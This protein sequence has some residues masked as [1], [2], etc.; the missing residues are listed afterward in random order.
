MR[1]AARQ[2]RAMQWL[3]EAAWAQFEKDGTDV[4]RLVTAHRGWLD[5]YGDYVLWSGVWE[6]GADEAIR[7]QLRERFRFEPRGWLVRDLAK[8]A[9][10]QAPPRLICGERPQ[11]FVAREAGIRYAVDPAAG[12]ASG[13][14]LDQRLNRAWARR[15]EA[16]RMLN[17]FAYTCSFSVCAALSG[18]TTSSVDSSRRALA[19]GKENFALN[20]LDVSAGHRFLAEDA[21]K[22][23]R[24]LAKRG[25]AF[26]L[27]VLDPP[28]FGRADGQTFRIE[29]DFAGLIAVCFEVLEPGGW[30]LASCNYAPWDSRALRGICHSALAVHAF[31]I[32][33]GEPPPE[34]PRGAVSCRIRRRS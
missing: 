34:I 7:K 23:V 30:L 31:A 26:D 32:E 5:R 3:S 19:R 4:H 18:A 14:F 13:I 2:Y 28:T 24:R 8:A 11:P 15:L 17:L 20:S 12:Y 27:I 33:P 22:Y 25:E 10:D 9:E 16:R 29:R 6:Q 21:P 1:D